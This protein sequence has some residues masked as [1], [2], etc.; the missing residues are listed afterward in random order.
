MILRLAAVCESARE[1]HDGRIDMSGIFS[2]LSAPGF[3]ARQDEMFVVFVIEWG[4]DEAGEQPLRADLVDQRDR[5]V[6]TIQGGTEVDARGPDR[7]PART[8][9][10]MRLENVVFREPGRYRFDLVAGGDVVE[11]CAF[12][13]GL[14][15]ED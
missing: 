4:A 10:V 1:R 14:V 8:Q 3:P 7:P 5:K 12:H 2:E 11:A 15:P 6:L 9:L 13:V